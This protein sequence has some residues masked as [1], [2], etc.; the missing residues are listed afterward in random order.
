MV[1]AIQADGSPTWLDQIRGRFLHPTDESL[2]RYADE[3]L[4][5]V[6]GGIAE[7]VHEVVGDEDDA[8][9]SVD[10]SAQLETRK[11]ARTDKSGKREGRSEGGAAGSSRPGEVRQGS[12]PDD[13]ATLTEHMK[14]KAL[15][16]HKRRLDEQAAALLAAKR[17]KLQKDAPPAPFR[18]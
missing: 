1:E 16:D 3:V 15:A 5:T 13:T 7:P 11:K 14:E 10:P 2:S 6:P 9:A 8:E 18:I 12:D 17:A 4:G